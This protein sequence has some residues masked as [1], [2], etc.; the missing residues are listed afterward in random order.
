[1]PVNVPVTRHCLIDDCQKSYKWGRYCPMHA[2]RL[3][4]YGT[5]LKTK[6]P[7]HGLVSTPGYASWK[8]MRARCYTKTNR[9][10]KDYGARGIE[11]CERWRESFTN[12]YQDMGAKPGQEYS[13]NRINND[14]NYEPTNCEWATPE[15]QAN[16]KRVNLFVTH[17]GKTRTVAQWARD[18]GIPATSIVWRINNG[19]TGSEVLYG[20]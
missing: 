11:V 17:E 9:K 18:L 14:G 15:V 7:N 10:Y 2:K 12:F 13:L 19:R 16:N 8:G 6:R 5:P 3:R 20:N 4:R 1:M